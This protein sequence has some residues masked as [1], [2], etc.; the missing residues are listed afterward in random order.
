MTGM[1]RCAGFSLIELVLMIV[2]LAM[3]SVG[4]MAAYRLNI[5]GV[6][7]NAAITTA[8][9]IAQERMEIVLAQR[10]GVGFAAFVD[11]CAGATPAAVCPVLPAGYAIAAPTVSA[12]DANTRAIV[13][14]ATFNGVPRA[15]L[16]TQVSNY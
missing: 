13:V 3:G 2:I 11:P 1:T 16:Q 15:T 4:I 7:D 6:A 14:E 9:R 8:T 5:L 10:R 12:V